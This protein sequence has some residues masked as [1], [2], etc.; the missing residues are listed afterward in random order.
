MFLKVNSIPSDWYI[1]KT[2]V[3]KDK[4]DFIDYTS[5]PNSWT[6]ELAGVSLVLQYLQGY[7]FRTFGH[8]KANTKSQLTAVHAAAVALDES[9]ESILDDLS[10]MYPTLH[11]VMQAFADKGYAIHS[12]GPK[13]I[14][15]TIDDIKGMIYEYGGI[16]L[17]CKLTD[18][19]YNAHGYDIDS[20]GT[21]INESFTKG[22]IA[23]GFDSDYVYVQNSLGINAG[24]IGF[25]RIPWKIIPQLVVCGACY[26][27][28]NN[29][30][31]S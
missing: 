28:T 26:G 6:D 5:S 20:A 31:S 27:L 8:K 23:Y 9:L 21:E 18:T 7:N 4:C 19:T 24:S 1:S 17:E 16:I 25:H 14:K 29:L 30:I 11:S 15:N 12:E 3:V 10:E 2:P 13:M 22:F